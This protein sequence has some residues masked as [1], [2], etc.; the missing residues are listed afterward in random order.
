MNR[1]LIALVIGIVAGIIDIIPMIIQKESKFATIS[2]F[3]HWV[4]LGII[5]PFVNWGIT[6][7]LTGF[8]IGE[9]SAIP[10]VT[11]VYPIDK[12]ALIPILVMSAILGTAIGLI[13]GRFI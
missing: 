3:V 8:I 10:V 9:L 13:G 1:I 6:P 7:W 5:I 12:K 4:A 2:A 11:M